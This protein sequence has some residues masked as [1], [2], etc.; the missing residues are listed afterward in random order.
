MWLSQVVDDWVYMSLIFDRLLLY[1]YAIVTLAGTLSILMNAP[2]I[3]TE[4]DQQAFKHQVALERCC[5]ES[6]P[7]PAETL[8]A[9]LDNTQ[10]DEFKYEFLYLWLMS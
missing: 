5:K 1:I 7:S 4:F 3:F 8:Q 10:S 2:H 9:C 6:Y